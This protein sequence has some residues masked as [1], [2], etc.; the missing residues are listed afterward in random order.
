ME[1]SATR[2]S[3]NDYLRQEPQ[4]SGDIEKTNNGFQITINKHTYNNPRPGRNNEEIETHSRTIS[5][6]AFKNLTQ[7]RLHEI[8]EELLEHFDRN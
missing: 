4:F 5:H 7:G 3:I 8:I 1:I 6:Q 2:Q